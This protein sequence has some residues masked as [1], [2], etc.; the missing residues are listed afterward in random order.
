MNDEEIMNVWL[1]MTGKAEGLIEAGVNANL[2]V[3]FARAII[4]LNNQQTP[5][6][7]KQ[8][9]TKKQRPGRKAK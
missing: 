6:G 9:G 4:S 1:H 7:L 5:Y 8:D 2:P 3:M